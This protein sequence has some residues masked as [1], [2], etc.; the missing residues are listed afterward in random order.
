MIFSAAP[1]EDTLVAL[2]GIA[3]ELALH[4][5]SQLQQQ[6]AGALTHGRVDHQLG[7]GRQRRALTQCLAHGQRVVDQPHADSEL[8]RGR[9]AVQSHVGDG[10]GGELTSRQSDRLERAGLDLPGVD[11]DGISGHRGEAEA[12]QHVEDQNFGRGAHFRS[13]HGG[14]VWQQRD[15]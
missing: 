10:A 3:V 5:I 8:S 1:A 11:A 13:P 4:I 6:L 15:L 14:I 12:F 9:G 2:A 7:R